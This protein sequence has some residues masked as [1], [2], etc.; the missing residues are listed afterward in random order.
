MDVP[1]GATMREVRKGIEDRCLLCLE[2]MDDHTV[3]IA[4]CSEHGVTE[5]RPIGWRCPNA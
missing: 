5:L 2:P 4:E 3:M 1:T